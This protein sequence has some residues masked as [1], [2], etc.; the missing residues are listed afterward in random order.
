[1]SV[2]RHV[3]VT[4]PAKVNLGLEILGRRRDGYHEIRTIMVMLDL[5]DVLDVAVVAGGRG[6]TVTGVPGVTQSDNLVVRAAERFAESTGIEAAHA[7]AVTKRIPSPAG[8][9]GASADAAATLVAL[10]MLH[11][12][13]LG[14]ID[15][16]SVSASLGS[17][18]PFFLGAPIA[19]V[20]GRGTE[21]MG[22]PQVHGHLVIAVPRTGMA[23]K[24]ATLYS[25]LSAEDFSDGSRTGELVAAIK[26]GRDIDPELLENAFERPLAALAPDAVGMDDAM[27]EAGCP[28]VALS[29]AGPA[30]YALFDDEQ[31]ARTT[32]MA[33]QARV[34]PEVTVIVTRFRHEPVAVEPS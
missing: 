5:A 2:G 21:L 34:G 6:T 14:A 30:H 25:L 26:Q 13:P 10:N 12:G 23:A 9:G 32:A 7:I 29:G 11:G 19:H 24:T 4:A 28:H 17:D 16:E 20:S 27:R 22:L 3:R 1:M 18:V 15:M 31:A 33:L 8:L